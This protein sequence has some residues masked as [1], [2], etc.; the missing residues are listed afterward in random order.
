DWDILAK[1]ARW[2]RDHATILQD[3]HWIGGDPGE[4]QVYGWAAWS[5]HG[6]I[7]TLRNPSTQPQTFNLTLAAAL[8]LLPQHRGT[9]TVTQPFAAPTLAPQHWR[10]DQTVALP[11][12]PFEVRIFES[13]GTP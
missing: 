3:V 13:A 11:L 4:L 5:P 9:F 2:S 8:E 12:Q 1:A 6:W 7:V 10:S